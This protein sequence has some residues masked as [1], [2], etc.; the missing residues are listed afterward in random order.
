MYGTMPMHVVT[1]TSASLQEETVC[2]HMGAKGHVGYANDLCREVSS[3]CDTL[4]M[5][6]WCREGV[7]DRRG[8]GT[9]TLR[10]LLLGAQSA[11][12]RIVQKQCYYAPQSCRL[13]IMITFNTL[14]SQG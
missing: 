10:V 13:T 9:T 5:R 3:M 6:D 14:A 8:W 7:E 2:C 11:V 12:I 1:L 4:I